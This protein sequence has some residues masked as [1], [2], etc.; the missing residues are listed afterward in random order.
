MSKVVAPPHLVLIKPLEETKS[1]IY[2]GTEDELPTQGTV[3]SVGEDVVSGW[4]DQEVIFKKF[5]TQAFKF[6]EETY[7][8]VDVKDIV[9]IITKA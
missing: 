6:Q 8:A 2:V 3:V 9:A 1:A 7:L 4:L 5:S